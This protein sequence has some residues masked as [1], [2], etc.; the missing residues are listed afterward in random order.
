M[1]RDGPLPPHWMA[2]ASES[3]EVGTVAGPRACFGLMLQWGAGSNLHGGAMLMDR[4][5]ITPKKYDD[6]ILF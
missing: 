3:E 6:N 5:N 1:M 2:A 4:L